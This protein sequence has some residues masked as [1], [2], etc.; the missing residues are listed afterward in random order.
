[1]TQGSKLWFHNPLS[2]TRAEFFGDISPSRDPNLHL[3]LRLVKDTRN[4]VVDTDGLGL[5]GC[6]T[7]VELLDPDYV[8][9]RRCAKA[10]EELQTEDLPTQAS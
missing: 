6:G 3:E 9:G 5:Q 4:I 10:Y 1:M 8:V 2:F 7:R